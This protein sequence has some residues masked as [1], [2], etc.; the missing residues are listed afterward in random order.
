MEMM[1]DMILSVLNRAGKPKIQKSKNHIVLS[2]WFA[3]L[4][5]GRGI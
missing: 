2:L 3:C 1:S 4:P 5:V